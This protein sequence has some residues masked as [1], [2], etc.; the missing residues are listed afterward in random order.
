M[1][2]FR[3]ND[4]ESRSWGASAMS[5]DLGRGP[6]YLL[7]LAVVVVVVAFMI[8][9]ANASLDEVTRGNARVVP[10]QKVQVVQNL[11]GGILN[12]LDVHEGDLVEEGQLLA[13]LDKTQLQST[14]QESRKRYD[15]LR[16]VVARLEAEAEDRPLTFPDDL[17]ANAP[18]IVA[19]QR[20]LYEM[21]QRELRST[22]QVHDARI[23]QRG[24]EIAELESRREQIE[25]TL[26]LARKELAMTEP[27]AARNIVPQINLIRTQRDVTDL[28]GELRTIELSIERARSAL[29]EAEVQREEAVANFTT[30]AAEE[31]S[32]RRAELDVVEERVTA[33]LDRVVRTNVRS[34]I[35]GTIKEIY[36][37]TV[38]GVVKPGEEILEIVPR[39]GTLLIEAQI[40]PAD[41]AFLHPN[42]L[43]KVKITA[44]DFSIYGGLDGRVERISADTITDAD[45]NSFY[46]V[47]VRTQ[48]N[49]LTHQGERLPIIPGMTA[50]VDILTGEKTVLDYLLKPILKVKNEALR[51]K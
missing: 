39:D 28:S 41:I 26:V 16:G 10:S 7:S 45:G 29:T 33:G 35:R 31:L 48:D 47:Y 24:R 25:S 43:A 51:E 11:E 8:W 46:R 20:E 21:R 9:A 49:A 12:S 42:Q 14:F 50:Q 34:P 5:Q 27:L 4:A 18:E 44:Y 17:K 2:L 1:G 32:E 40:R 23:H 13:T 22:L 6:A 15:N 19:E 37:N 30:R 36:K 3:R 38:G